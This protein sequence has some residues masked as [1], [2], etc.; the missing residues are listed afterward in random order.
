[1]E[2]V[3][4]EKEVHALGEYLGVR[5]GL[6]PG[7]VK[8]GVVEMERGSYAGL[9]RVGGPYPTRAKAGYET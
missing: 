6:W 4:T 9:Y 7:G 8:G 1:M 3:V 5:V 2:H